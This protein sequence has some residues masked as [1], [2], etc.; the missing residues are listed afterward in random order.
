[1]EKKQN[2]TIRSAEKGGDVMLLHVV[3]EF[4]AGVMEM[5]IAGVVHGNFSSTVVRSLGACCEAHLIC[6]NSSATT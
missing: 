4:N 5:T 2:W 1:M 3:V 6:S